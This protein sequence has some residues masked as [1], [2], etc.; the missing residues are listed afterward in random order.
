M[1]ANNM[2]CFS[3][4]VEVLWLPID[5][6]HKL[7]KIGIRCIVEEDADI[8]AMQSALLETGDVAIGI[9]HSGTNKGVLECLK[10]A[11]ANGAVDDWTYH[12]M[13]NRLCK[14]CVIMC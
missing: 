11:K 12:I 5:A 2:W 6:L 1:Y 8:Q 4:Q 10:N 13:E 7:L 14:K 9:S 3:E